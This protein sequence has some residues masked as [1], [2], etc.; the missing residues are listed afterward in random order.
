MSFLGKYDEII[1]EF[2]IINQRTLST[3]KLKTDNITICMSYLI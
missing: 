1:I 2:G 3:S